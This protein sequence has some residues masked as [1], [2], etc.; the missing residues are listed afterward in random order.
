MSQIHSILCCCGSGIGSSILTEMNLR[1]ALIKLGRT[2]IVSGHAA[3][4]EIA[5]KDADLIVT[6]KEMLDQVRAFPRVI[7]LTRMIS[8]AELTAKLEAAFSEE[9]DEFMIQ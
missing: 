3:L 5:D 6:G 1:K 4:S 9:R 2:D 8:E 7:A